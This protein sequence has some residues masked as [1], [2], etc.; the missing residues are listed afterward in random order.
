MAKAPEDVISNAEGL[1]YTVEKSLEDYSHLLSELDRIDT[2]VAVQTLKLLV[3][4]AKVDTIE[5]GIRELTA[6][7]HRLAE[8]MY[9]DARDGGE[10]A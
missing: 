4:G 1:I 8:A 10:D 3:T 7:A 9:R 6:L 5:I 2:Q